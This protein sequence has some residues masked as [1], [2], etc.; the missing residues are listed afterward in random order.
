MNIVKI[1]QYDFPMSEIDGN[2][3]E[4][5]TQTL[6]DE[7]VLPAFF[8]ARLKWGE[9]CRTLSRIGNQGRCK[10]GWVSIH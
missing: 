1:D 6:N 3:N 4:T 9:M 10:S 5:T 2:V 7:P 8:D